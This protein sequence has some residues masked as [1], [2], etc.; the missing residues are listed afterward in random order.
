MSRIW[1]KV[2]TIGVIILF[3]VGFRSMILT[4]AAVGD[5]FESLME[6]LPFAE[7]FS[8]IICNVMKFQNGQPFISTTGFIADTAKL[9]V[10]SCIQPVLTALLM[11]I[12]LRMP[13]GLDSFGM[14][15]FMKRPGYVI[16]EFLIKII[17]APVSAVAAGYLMNWFMGWS[18]AKF[19][20]L[21]SM[22]LGL[23]ST[24]VAL[25]LSALP[26]ILLGAAVS[27]AFLWRFVVTL[28]GG[29]LK[30]LVIIISSIFAYYAFLNGIPSQMAGAVISLF[31]LLL[32][33]EIVINC[34]Q[35]IL[36]AYSAS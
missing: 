8:K 2:A 31:V 34:F 35:Q 24:V 16:K 11:F 10:M 1:T 20:T 14:E 15:S 32:I 27:V 3:I 4:D 9:M 29:M 22:L 17:T 26:M 23:L 12:F 18:A 33:V 36:G 5:A 28:I 30:S 19:G 7:P 13:S 25:G 21:G 6:S